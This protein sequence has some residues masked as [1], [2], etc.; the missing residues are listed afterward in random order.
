LTLLDNVLLGTYLRT[1]AGFAVG[2]A[3]LDR[4]EEGQARAEALHQL[5]R[6]G[7]TEKAQSHAGNL[8]LGSQ[9]M[10]NYHHQA[11]SRL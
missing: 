4:G 5:R 8:P 9:R 6:V 3:R 1:R 7:L 11:A 10:M 2:A